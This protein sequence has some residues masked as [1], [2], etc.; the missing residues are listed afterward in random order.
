MSEAVQASEGYP[1]ML[2]AWIDGLNGYAHLYTNDPDLTADTVADDFEEIVYD[3]YEPLPVRPWT[4]PTLRDGLAIAVVD[5]LIFTFTG[6]PL[7]A[8]ARGY[9]VTDGPAGRLLWAWRRPGNA[10][11]M[12]EDA[13][14]VIVYIRARWPLICE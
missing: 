4:T 14:T 11:Q 9:Y 8:P 10:F 7:P 13:P 12:A 1:A 3:R 2:A 6:G 5:P